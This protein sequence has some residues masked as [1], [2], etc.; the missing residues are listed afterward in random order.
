M[1][2]VLA[3]TQQLAT[4]IC[5]NCGVCFG[6]PIDMQKRRIEDKALF[7]CPNGHGQ[8]YTGESEAEKLKRE[9]EAAK[10]AHAAELEWQRSRREAAERSAAAA[11]GQVTKIRNRVG[12]GVCPCCNRT[13]Q[14]LQRHMHTKHPDFKREEPAP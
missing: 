8:R 5:C 1:G 6:M 2:A 14:N 10:K 12:N 9:L 7:Y 3:F 11:R 13:F 4:E